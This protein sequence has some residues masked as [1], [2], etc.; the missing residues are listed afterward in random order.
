MTS[1]NNVLHVEPKQRVN[2]RAAIDSWPRGAEFILIVRWKT[3]S[4][5]KNPQTYLLSTFQSSLFS[6]RS[7]L[8]CSLLFGNSFV[9]FQ[10]CFHERRNNRTRGFSTSKVSLLPI[11]WLNK[12]TME[13]NSRI[14][15]TRLKG[16]P[17]W[18]TKTTQLKIMAS[19]SGYSHI[20]EKYCWQST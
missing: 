9:E 1:W 16:I 10:N 19:P 3:V 6:V 8:I 18:I 13:L 15:L 7:V 11:S 20:S 17:L 12:T 5:F 14:E 4:H 2:G